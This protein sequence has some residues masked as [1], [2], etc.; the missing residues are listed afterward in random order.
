MEMIKRA[1]E[2]E[3]VR[4]FEYSTVVYHSYTFIFQER[5]FQ[6]AAEAEREAHLAAQRAEQ[7]RAESDAELQKQR[8]RQDE[9]RHRHR[10]MSD[11]TEMPE[12]SVGADM[13]VEGFSKTIEF[14]GYA[15]NSVKI[16]HP[17]KGK[18]V[19]VGIYLVYNQH[20]LYRVPWYDL[21]G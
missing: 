10:A 4:R 8:Q 11:A 21:F 6:K 2:A 19:P 5:Q 12:G 14:G 18:S 3:R 1:S 20:T 13:V 9:N 16:F 15:F 7:F 17:R